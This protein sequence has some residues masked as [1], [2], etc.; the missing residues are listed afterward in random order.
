MLRGGRVTRCKCVYLPNVIKSN[1]SYPEFPSVGFANGIQKRL[2]LK[3]CDPRAVGWV[4]GA[5]A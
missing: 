3:L 5:A 2:S 4:D 1:K